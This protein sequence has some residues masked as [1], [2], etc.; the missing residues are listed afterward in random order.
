MQPH[1]AT[2]IPTPGAAEQ[3][4]GELGAPRPHQA[5]DAEDLSAPYGHRYT[6]DDLAL[7]VDRVVGVPVVDFEH[8][9]TDL[10]CA[11]RKSFV[12]VAAHHGLDHAALARRAQAAVD[13][14]DG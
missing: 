2:D 12:H 14:F 6:L 3:A 4:H 1:A 13:G 7:V 9:L 8:D 11:W 10:R 5:C